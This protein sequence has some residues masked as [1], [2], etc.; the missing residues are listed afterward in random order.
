MDFLPGQ[1]N[2]LANRWEPFVR[3]ISFEGFNYAGATFLMQV[4]LTRDAAGA[5]L[6][7]LDTNAPGVQGVSIDGVVTTDGIPTTTITIRINELAMEALPPGG[8]PGELGA[9]LT[10]WWD[11]QITPAGGG[12]KFR[13]LEG[14]FIVHAG[15][16]H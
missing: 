3:K 7:A 14:K 8:P 1:R 9:D 4:R 2:Y 16:T 12:D 13:A 15:V 6:I 5:A 11:L 10:L